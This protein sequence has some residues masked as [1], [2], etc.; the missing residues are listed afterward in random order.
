[1]E[2]IMKRREKRYVIM[3]N[4][5]KEILC[6][7]GVLL[8][9]VP[10]EDAQLKKIRTWPTES[11]AYAGFD[12]SWGYCDFPHEAVAMTTTYEISEDEDVNT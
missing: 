3:R 9:F 10:L 2:G 8:S 12:R 6:G 7:K 1:M 5:R 11:Y 4:E